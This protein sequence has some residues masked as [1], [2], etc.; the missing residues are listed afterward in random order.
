MINQ[1]KTNNTQVGFRMKNGLK[2]NGMFKPSARVCIE[3]I[4]A[5]K[6]I[7]DSLMNSTLGE[8]KSPEFDTIML[9]S[10]V[11]LY[12]NMPLKNSRDVRF[13]EL[14][15]LIRLACR[16]N[17]SPEWVARIKEFLCSSQKYVTKVRLFMAISI[18]ALG[19]YVD[20]KTGSMR[21]CERFE[22]IQTKAARHLNLTVYESTTIGQF[23]DHISYP[24][25]HWNSAKPIDAFVDYAYS[26]C[27]IINIFMLEYLRKGY[28]EMFSIAA[29]K[30]RLAEKEPN[31]NPSWFYS[32]Y[33]SSYEDVDY[34]IEAYER[35]EENFDDI[36][37]E[38]YFGDEEICEEA[39]FEYYD[40]DV[41]IDFDD[42][43]DEYEDDDTDPDSVD[44]F[45]KKAM[46]Q[47]G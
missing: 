19:D 17:N 40:D 25:N 41:L 31:W 34:D 26:C 39:L 47:E 2:F 6:K 9:G 38:D 4:E 22:D 24:M 3:D 12:F 32:K 45:R 15:N 13:G 23:F 18:K 37:C 21:C 10:S 7:T 14:L 43:D 16:D 42:E 8:L 33:E 29:L 28:R 11:L 27:E 35:E 20:L 44:I 46:G 36:D 30:D 1:E 5:V